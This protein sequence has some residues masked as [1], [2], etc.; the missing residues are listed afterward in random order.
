MGNRLYRALG[1]LLL[2]GLFLFASV[3]PARAATVT[4]TAVRVGQYTDYTRTV[5]EANGT[6]TYATSTVAAPDRI[7]VDV[8]N[9]TLGS[10]TSP[11]DVDDG[12]VRQI[13]WSQ[14]S[15]TVVRVVIELE[16][17]MPY[18]V[19]TLTGPFRIVVDVNKQKSNQTAP[20]IRVG[21]L[22]QQSEVAFGGTGAFDIINLATGGKIA[23]GTANTTWKVTSDATGYGVYNPTGTK[24]G[25]YTGPIRVKLQTP[26]SYRLTAKGLQYR[27]E[28]EVKKN[29][30]NQI[31]LI[32]EVDTESYLYGVVPKEMSSA[33]NAN[34]LRA[35]AMAARTYA[36]AN[37]GRRTA[38]GCDLYDSTE[39]QVYGGASGEAT[40]STTAVNDTRGT[41]MI[42]NGAPINALFHSTAGGYT[43]NNDNVFDQPA[44]PYLR[45]VATTWESA[46]PVYN[47]TATITNA[48]MQT[49]LNAD[50]ETAVGTLQAITPR[51]QGVSG[52]WLW[53]DV[54]GSQGTKTVRSDKFR[55]V[56]G[57]GTIKSTL[58]T[59]T[60][61]GTDWAFSGKGY[62]HGVGMPQYSAKGMGD[63]GYGFRK[64]LRT[65]YTDLIR[66]QVQY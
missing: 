19:S 53:V 10:I 18:V 16:V 2:S 28:F 30:T 41:V 27:G 13:R 4:V 25:T 24:V 33:W 7:I 3:A 11:L 15:P 47:W 66:F 21:L 9:A 45:G 31:A 62:G 60:R 56:V 42:Y 44:E 36:R 22:W 58:F 12:T 32:N 23:T 35:Q 65:F 17:A 55:K 5:I 20:A 14:Y 40:S 48:N 64:I 34:A 57:A 46:S 26:A 63:A 6:T 50:P 61:S 1:A 59:M 54:T 43:E 29:A 8:N 52:R 38:D 49:L 37:M 51:G 39:D